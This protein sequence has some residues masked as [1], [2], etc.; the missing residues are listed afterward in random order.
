MFNSVFKKFISII[1]NIFIRLFIIQNLFGKKNV[2]INIV[3][4]FNEND[5]EVI[6]SK[7]EKIL[8]IIIFL[9]CN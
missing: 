4:Q 2:K 1:H 9:N 3:N 6:G 5:D 7:I 8:L